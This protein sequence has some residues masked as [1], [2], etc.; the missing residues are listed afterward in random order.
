MPPPRLVVLVGTE[1]PGLTAASLS[2]YRNVRIPMDAGVDSLNVSH[3][4]A[5]A[6]ALLRAAGVRR[7]SGPG[8]G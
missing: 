8:A 2:R 3:A 7:R 6:L 5:V 1:G 4:V